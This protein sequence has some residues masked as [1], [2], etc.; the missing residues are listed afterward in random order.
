MV[1][2]AGSMSLKSSIRAVSGLAGWFASGATATIVAV[3]LLSPQL[4]TQ[5]TAQEAKG[6]VGQECIENDDYGQTAGY[7][8]GAAD[9]NNSR[10]TRSDVHVSDVAFCQRI[11][12]VYVFSV[13]GGSFEYGYVIGW[14]FCPG[15]GY[16]HHQNPTEFWWSVTD[17]GNTDCHIWD[18]RHP[19]SGQSDN[20]RVSDINANSYWGS[21]FNGNE[22]QPSG[23]NMDF[24]H[25]ISFIG[26]ERGHS[27]DNG[28]ARFDDLTE[29]HTSDEWSHWDHLDRYD[30][31]P[32]DPD[33]HLDILT[34]HSGRVIHGAG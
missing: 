20:F 3:A 33:Y 4:L 34:N 7:E 24:S 31:H 6:R 1:K 29:W 27:N 26:A 15:E 21:Y 8:H 16:D 5:A 11:S 14:S 23:V 25:G 28:F 30:A 12:S 9:I 13:N 10:A 22:L 18:Q 17:N 19:N 32:N 2:T